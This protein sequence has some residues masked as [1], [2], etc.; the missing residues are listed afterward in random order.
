M[1]NNASML[2]T[3][4]ELTTEYTSYLEQEQSDSE[5]QDQSMQDYQLSDSEEL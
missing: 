1:M 4:G 3:H 2:A 5:Q